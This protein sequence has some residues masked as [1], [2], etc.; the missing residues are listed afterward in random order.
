MKSRLN[1]S[2]Q[3]Q[4]GMRSTFPKFTIA[5]P[6]PDHPVSTPAYHHSPRCCP[7]LSSH[8][9]SSSAPTPRFC[10]SAAYLSCRTMLPNAC[11]SSALTMLGVF[12]AQSYSL[13]FLLNYCAIVRRS[14]SPRRI[15]TEL[16]VNSRAS[17]SDSSPLTSYEPCHCTLLTR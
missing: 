1:K 15:R 10:S 2:N 8:S 4:G 16:H 11:L 3:R 7:F 6:C 14:F 5:P 17:F 12:S 9:S 13:L